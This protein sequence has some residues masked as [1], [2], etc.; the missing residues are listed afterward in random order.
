MAEPSSDDLEA[1]LEEQQMLLETSLPLVFD[2]FDEAVKKRTKNPVVILLDCE[3]AIGGEIARSWLGEEAVDDAI[4]HQ[5]ADDPS[6]DETTVFATAFSLAECQRELPPVFPYL[7]PALRT[8]PAEGFL[9]VSVAA[10]G[11][12]VLI[13][14]PDARP[15]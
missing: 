11:A 10:G 9:A 7:E 8:P 6:S 5:A 15:S 2:A 14:P 13:V 1:A 12:S 3:D 4:A